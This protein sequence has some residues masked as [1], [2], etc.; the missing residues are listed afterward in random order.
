MDIAFR[1][2]LQQHQKAVIIGS[3]CASLTK[4][5]IEEAFRKLDDHDYVIGPATDGG[6][7]ACFDGQATV[8]VA[9]PLK[10]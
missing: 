1:S 5:I 2:V 9:S 7:W 6:Y 4:E 10:G 8:D 3:D